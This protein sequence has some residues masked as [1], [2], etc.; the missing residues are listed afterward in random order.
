MGALG[1]L[2]ALGLFQMDGGASVNSSYEITAP[3][4]DEIEIELNP[5]YY[6][7]DKFSIIVEN[8]SADHPYIQQAQLN[9]KEWRSVF[10]SHETFALGGELKIMLGKD[11][12]RDWGHLGD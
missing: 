10:F 7:G 4:F 1:V 11:P 3:V 6:P 12:N 8:N 2:M 9:G 5:T